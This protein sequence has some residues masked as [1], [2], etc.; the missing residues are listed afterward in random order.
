[1]SY[2][3]HIQNSSSHTGNIVYLTIIIVSYIIYQRDIDGA[4]NDQQLLSVGI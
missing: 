3:I 1:M 2:Y 4:H